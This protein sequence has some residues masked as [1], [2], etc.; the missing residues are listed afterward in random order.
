LSVTFTPPEVAEIA[1][2][3]GV[4]DA[5]KIRQLQR[6]L[7]RI[8][9]FAPTART[10][11]QAPPPSRSRR[12]AQAIR[13]HVAALLKE[14]EGAAAESPKGA[15]RSAKP[16][17]LIVWQ[18]ADR[19][20]RARTELRLRS[21]RERV[22]QLTD[23]LRELQAAAE[24][25]LA[26]EE[27]RVAAGHGG[28]RRKGDEGLWLVAELLMDALENATGEK[29]GVSHT[30]PSKKPARGD[31]SERRGP[32]GPTIRF[33]QLTLPRLGWV[34]APATMRDLIRRYQA[35]KH[36]DRIKPKDS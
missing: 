21:A 25:V 6:D 27:R 32:G 12:T 35:E 5:G 36:R 33:L 16:I 15:G 1:S 34:V 9:D 23:N 7:D 22:Q 2:A 11:D 29:V 8:A 3:I 17:N 20:G 26:Q 30:Q 19:S 4:E 24:G 18:M 10:Y 13:R 14:L 28:S 31:H